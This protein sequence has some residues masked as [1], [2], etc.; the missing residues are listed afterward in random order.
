MGQPAIKVPSHVTNADAY[1]KAAQRN[2]LINAAKTRSE[3]WLAKHNDAQTLS[4][5]LHG[6]GEFA[7]T[8]E[9]KNPDDQEAYDAKVAASIDLYE[10]AAIHDEFDAHCV[11]NPLCEGMFSGDFGQILLNLRDAL[12]DYGS[13]TDKQ[14]EIV[15]QALARARDRQALRE[16]KAARR[17]ERDA[18]SEYIGKIKERR[19]FVLTINKVLKFPNA[20][21]G[22]TYLNIMRDGDGNV[23]IGKGTKQYGYEGATI[24]VTATIVAHK[25]REGVKQTFINRPKKK[26][27]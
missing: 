7:D 21:G 4:D 10:L 24:T 25:E 13:L 22:T 9:T 8:M 20:F 5:W 27:D 11:T 2:I 19:E 3:Q 14:T 6:C 18:K 26:V 1:V 17:R 12:F 23:V 16:Q 15:R